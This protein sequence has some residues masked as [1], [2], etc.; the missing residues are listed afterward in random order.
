MSWTVHISVIT[1]Y[2]TIQCISW[3]DLNIFRL[4]SQ[5]LLVN[6]YITTFSSFFETVFCSLATQAASLHKLESESS[7][8]GRKLEEAVMRG[9]KWTS[10][11]R[12]FVVSW[13]S[14]SLYFIK[15]RLCHIPSG[16]SLRKKL[17]FCDT[18][19][20]FAAKWHL[21]NKPK[22]SILIHH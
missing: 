2:Y 19:T 4:P 21:R 1:W 17:T 22:Y 14:I 10:V 5:E 7:A 12:I 20:G 18:S 16:F 3:S 9:G 6:Y 8:A 11:I 13:R 15:Q